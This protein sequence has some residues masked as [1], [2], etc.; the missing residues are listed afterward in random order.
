MIEKIEFEKEDKILTFLLFP[1][2]IIILVCNIIASEIFL[3]MMKK[4][5]CGSEKFIRGRG[6]LECLKCERTWGGTPRNEKGEQTR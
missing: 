4:C 5:P 6:Y 3:R 1:F 2:F